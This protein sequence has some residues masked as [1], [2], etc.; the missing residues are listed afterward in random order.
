M[1]KGKKKSDNK[2]KRGAERLLTF[3]LAPSV[4]A[5]SG[6]LTCSPGRIVA[7]S[8]HS[9]KGSDTYLVFLE[10]MPN[11]IEVERGAYLEL[12]KAMAHVAHSRP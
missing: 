5:D 7:V 1:T 2:G 6:E 9:R 11:W 12:K 3:P 8:R 4:S 10:G